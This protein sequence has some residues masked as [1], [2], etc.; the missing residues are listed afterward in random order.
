M[1]RRWAVFQISVVVAQQVTL[2]F[3]MPWLPQ[4]H[5]LTHMQSPTTISFLYAYS[6]S[7]ICL[8][9]ICRPTCKLFQIK[10]SASWI[11]LN[12]MKKRLNALFYCAGEAICFGIKF[13][14]VYHGLLPF[15]FFSLIFSPINLSWQA[16]THN[17]FS[18]I[19]QQLPTREVEGY[20]VFLLSIFF[21]YC[22]CKV[23]CS[24]THLEEHVNSPLLYAWAYRH[25]WLMFVTVFVLDGEYATPPLP[26]STC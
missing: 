8:S 17:Q 24:V 15:L 3:K 14:A 5:C 4:C 9:S 10:A 6:F 25:S 12:I 11:N 23:R 1:T 22:S 18:R 21:N 7:S 13:K 20:H 16:P 26:E 19:T 2:F